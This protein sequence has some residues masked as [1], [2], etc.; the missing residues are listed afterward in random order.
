M[1]QACGFPA[2]LAQTGWLNNSALHASNNS[3]TDPVW[4]PMLGCPEG[5][6]V[7]RVRVWGASIR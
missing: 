6:N 1:G 7:C 4:T 5:D 3:A 2:R